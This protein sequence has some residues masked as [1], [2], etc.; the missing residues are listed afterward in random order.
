MN[1]GKNYQ[2]VM[3]RKLNQNGGK[4]TKRQIQDE[5]SRENPSF[6]EG[7]NMHGPNI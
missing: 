2:P 1:D 6:Y 7:G 4:A 3:I 5:L